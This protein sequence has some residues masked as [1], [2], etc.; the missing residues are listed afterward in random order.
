MENASQATELEFLELAGALDRFAE[1][2]P[3]A[4]PVEL[5]ALWPEL[6]RRVLKRV[7]AGERESES[8][9]LDLANAPRSESE[10]IRNLAWEIGVSV[11]LHAVHLGAL[12]ALTKLLRERGQRVGRRGSRDAIARSQA[13]RS[14]GPT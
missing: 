2:A 10:R 13:S 9:A 8:A 3:G 4:H 12:R 6:E 14:E 1:R 5:V 7:S 11:D